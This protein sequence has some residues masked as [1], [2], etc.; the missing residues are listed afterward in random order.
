M[1]TFKDYVYSRP[2]VEAMKEQQ[3]ALIEQFKEAQS[4]EAQSELIEK[5][6]ELSNE[7]ATMANLVYIRA[8]IDTHDSFYQEERDYFDEV[9]P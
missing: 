8:S 5:L 2:N 3:L 1:T 9:G 6:N 4:V 7:Y